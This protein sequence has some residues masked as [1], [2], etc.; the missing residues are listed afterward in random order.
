MNI[1]AYHHE[2][3]DFNAMIN[4]RVHNSALRSFHRYASTW[5]D[6]QTDVRWKLAR[7]SDECERRAVNN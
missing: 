7:Y 5:L 6:Q 1:S 4:D 2:K 3:M